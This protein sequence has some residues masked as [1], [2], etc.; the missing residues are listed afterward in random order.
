ML[1]RLSMLRRLRLGERVVVLGAVSS[2]REGRC[3]LRGPF[4][5]SLP[6]KSGIA[7]SN[8]KSGFKVDF[9]LHFRGVSSALCE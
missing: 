5:L 9:G 4:V 1:Q 6:G 8:S 2:S 3:W 7:I